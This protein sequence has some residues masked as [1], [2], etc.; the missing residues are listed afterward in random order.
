MRQEGELVRGYSL[1][2]KSALLVLMWPLVGNV[3]LLV[4]MLL[5]RERALT[6][7][8]GVAIAT[9]VAVV[10]AAMLLSLWAMRECSLRDAMLVTVAVALGA[11][12]V[13]GLAASAFPLASTGGVFAI[14][15]SP[16]ATLW[17]WSRWLHSRP[18]RSAMLAAVRTLLILAAVSPVVSGALFYILSRSVDEAGLVLLT[19]LAGLASALVFM[20]VGRVVYAWRANPE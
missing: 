18:E 16:A 20:L 19:S 2:D 9:S 8:S 12:F 13:R 1:W 3:C 11:G 17:L 5:G 15:A 7:D 14:I 6:F 10:D 4:M